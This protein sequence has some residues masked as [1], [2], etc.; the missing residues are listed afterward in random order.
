MIKRFVKKSFFAVFTVF[1]AFNSFAEGSKEYVTQEI[2]A[3]ERCLP[4]FYENIKSRWTFKL[5]YK[6]GM[7]FNQ[8]QKDGLEKAR[9]LIIQEEDNTPFD[10]F[11][12]E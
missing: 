11:V 5:G 4:V 8:W 9:E 7:D 12:L 6:D 1:F 10:M 3:A 2:N